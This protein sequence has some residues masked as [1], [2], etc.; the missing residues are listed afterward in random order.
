[1]VVIDDPTQYAISKTDPS[2]KQKEQYKDKFMTLRDEPPSPS[3]DVVQLLFES[4]FPHANLISYAP[5]LLKTHFLFTDH[6]A[7]VSQR[8][9][10][11]QTNHR[12]AA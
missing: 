12:E 9:R 1:M 11:A 6:H 5:S 3:L 7:R 8:S 2:A 10:L 4:Q